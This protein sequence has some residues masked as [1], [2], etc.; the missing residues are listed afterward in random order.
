MDH[1]VL[2]C[3]LEPLSLAGAVPLAQRGEDADRHKHAGAGVAE[4]RARL[5]RRAVAVAG[6]AGR[7]A[8]GLRDHVEGEV[9]LVWAASAKAF[10]LAIDDPRVQ[11]LYGVV[12]EALP[13]ECP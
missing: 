5:Y 11:L 3:D 10:D 2:H 7:A 9:F 12:A 4:R 13:L 8:G 6:D 1:R